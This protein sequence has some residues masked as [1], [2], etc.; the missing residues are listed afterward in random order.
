MLV[1]LLQILH[2][3]CRKLGTTQTTS[4]KYGDHGVISFVS[5]LF[6]SECD[7]QGFALLRC[8][9]ITDPNSVFLGSF[10]TTNP[11]GQI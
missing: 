10:Y 4:K 3:Y 5:E 9:P 7:K 8:E 11:G 1:S 6:G 2:G